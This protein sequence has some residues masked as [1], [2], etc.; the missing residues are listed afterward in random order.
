[1]NT[2]Q[3]DTRSRTRS[4][5]SGATRTQEPAWS[6]TATESGWTGW[7]AFAAVV[8]MLM[9]VFH[10]IQG[11]VAIFRDDYYLVSANGLVVAL[12]YTA[13]GWIH[14]ALGIVV[15]CAG[16]A[17]VAGQLWARVVAVSLAFAS[18]LVNVVFLAAYPFWS[19]ARIA[20]DVVVIWA[21]TVHGDDMKVKR[22]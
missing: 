21:V 20:L 2:T 6:G 3:Q 10:A 4:S 7:I 14:L 17:L 12:D 18:A 13:W 15:L 1:M 5:S 19:L 16:F 11:L 22:S 9:G 8:M